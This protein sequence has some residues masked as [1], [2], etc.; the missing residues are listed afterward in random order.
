ML[1]Q[2]NSEQKE[3]DLLLQVKHV[4]EIIDSAAG[5]ES[6][7]SE[8]GFLHAALVRDLSEQISAISKT[9]AANM[10]KYCRPSLATRCWMPA[11]MMVAGARWLTSYVIGHQEDIKLWISDGLLTMRNYILHYILAPLRSGYE[12]IRYGKHTY[13]VMSDASLASD[14]HSL[15]EMVVGFAKRFGTVDP[16]S[17]R[18]RVAHGDLSDVMQVYANEMQQP[19]RNV[20]FGD[21]VQ[22]MLIQVQKVKVDVGQTMAAL[23]KLLRSNE[24]NFLLL[25]TVPATFSIYAAIKWLS[26]RVSWWTSGNNRHTVAS[27]RVIV[28]DIDRLL[29]TECKENEE[30]KTHLSSVSQGNLICL[31]NYLRYHTRG[32]PNLAS[33]GRLSIGSGWIHTLPYTRNMFIQ[34]IRDIEAA[35]FSVAQKQ[36]VVQRMYR[37]FKFL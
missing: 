24:L 4:I 28:R 25:S 20:L 36:Q 17:V 8:L 3:S 12:T 26:A 18:S 22:A 14:V 16:D 5:K 34:D 2:V 15:E 19:F 7:A 27:I 30:H 21:L 13:S 10:H 32:L 37:T 35:E 23:D 31:T 6:E 11:I 29:N 33:P 9:V 1:S